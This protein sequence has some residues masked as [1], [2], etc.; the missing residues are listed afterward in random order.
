MNKQLINQKEKTLLQM[1]SMKKP[2]QIHKQNAYIQSAKKELQSW[3]N[4]IKKIQE[5]E[6]QQI[7]NLEEKIL[8]KALSFKKM[9]YN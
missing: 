4:A 2:Q 6:P 7:K 3:K 9:F 1:E 8:K 5:L